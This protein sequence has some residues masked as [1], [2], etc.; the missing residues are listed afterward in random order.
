M[1]YGR[2]LLSNLDQIGVRGLALE[3]FRSYLSHRK[4]YVNLNGIS[5]ILKDLTIGVPHG[6]ISS[7]L[8]LLV[9]INELLFLSDLANLTLFAD[10]TTVVIRDDNI[11]NL[12]SKCNNY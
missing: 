12:S 9:Y 8:L 1:I 3:L 4:Q 11:D 5:S 7:P 2:P 6:S 10:D